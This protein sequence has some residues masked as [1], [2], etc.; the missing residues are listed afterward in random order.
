MTATKNYRVSSFVA[1]LAIK[2]PCKAV[3]NANLTL[4]G[5][6]TVN[7]VACVAGDRVLVKDQTTASENGI[8]VVETSAWQRS[9]DWDGE[10][11]AVNGT[12]VIVAGDPLISL[13]QLSVTGTFTIGTS[14]A[15][16]VLMSTLDLAG[17]LASTSNG[18]GASQV[19]IEDAGSFYTAA[20]VEAALAELFA[21]PSETTRR[22]LEIATA[23]E[24]VTATDDQRAITPLKLKQYHFSQAIAFQQWISD[25]VFS[26]IWTVAL[27]AS[28][29]Y[30]FR[31][32][33]LLDSDTTPGFKIRFNGSGGLTITGSVLGQLSHI[34][35]SSGVA[36]AFG[37]SGAL[38]IPFI[39]TTNTT[40]S[41]IV[42]VEGTINVNVAGDLN[43]QGAQN[44]SDAS[45]TEV[46]SGLLEVFKIR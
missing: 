9:G 28:T 3:S 35:S 15:T 2:A 21:T 16:F 37:V 17:T 34:N 7:T 39:L 44:V 5:E 41:H 40:G 10:R 30:G 8:W 26:T 4:S 29:L 12:I 20:D 13:Y 14:D 45:S 43:F 25:T 18:E 36:Q 27:E 19:A 22:L 1:D 6:Q 11:D 46:A 23:A 31:C 32:T 38:D 33:F 42:T 24:V